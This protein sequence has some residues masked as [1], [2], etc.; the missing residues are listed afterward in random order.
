MPR[1]AC[2]PLLRAAAS[3]TLYPCVSSYFGLCVL[4]DYMNGANSRSRG[5]V[6]ERLN[7]L[8]QSAAPRPT[9]REGE[10]EQASLAAAS[11]AAAFNKRD[12]R[13]KAEGLLREEK[14]VL[15]KRD[16]QPAASGDKPRWIARPPGESY[17]PRKGEETYIIR[18][19]RLTSR[20]WV[21][22]IG[23][24]CIDFAEKLDVPFENGEPGG[25]DG[26]LIKLVTKA[27]EQQSIDGR[28]HDR[29]TILFRQ[30]ITCDED[31]VGLLLGNE[32][33][34]P[35]L[36]FEY[37]IYLRLLSR[38]VR[39]RALASWMFESFLLACHAP[40]GCTLSASLCACALR[41]DT[42]D[43]NGPIQSWKRDGFTGFDPGQCS[44]LTVNDGVPS[45]DTINQR[46]SQRTMSSPSDSIEAAGVMSG[47]GTDAPGNVPS[48]G[49]SFSRS[50][51][52]AEQRDVASSLGENGDIG[53]KKDYVAVHLDFQR[54]GTG[55]VGLSVSPRDTRQPELCPLCQDE[56][57]PLV[58]G[59]P[60]I[61]CD[62]NHRLHIQCILDM[63]AT[64]RNRTLHIAVPSE[65]ATRRL[66]GSPSLG[67]AA[68]F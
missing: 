13:S 19:Y 21:D 55:T 4:A 68:V 54:D 40:E 49:G 67:I 51:P 9:L 24:E 1:D 29:A 38:D 15:C 10:E 65:D 31:I 22:D 48:T 17:L 45:K 43:M 61:N 64:P 33:P 60:T 11:I 8:R 20:Q 59:T 47:E 26:G 39:K 12:S 34:K 5:A 23:L 30:T 57:K 56:D 7:A 32:T 14:I 66:R 44:Q 2:S 16:G 63:E 18:T 25:P 36:D 42:D 50:H 37:T 62:R 41:G 52:C 35:R 27:V 3:P 6:R 58:A 46:R 28:G 53:V